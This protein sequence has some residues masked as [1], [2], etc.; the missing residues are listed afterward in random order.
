MSRSCEELLDPARYGQNLANADVIL[1]NA[2][3]LWP[4]NASEETG[5]E[6][7]MSVAL[8]DLKPSEVSR[9]RMAMQEAAFME[10]KVMIQSLETSH[11]ADELVGLAAASELS[12]LDWVVAVPKDAVPD[13]VQLKHVPGVGQS[14]LAGICIAV[15]DRPD[16]VDAEKFDLVVTEASNVS[17]VAGQVFRML[18]TLT[19]SYTLTCLDSVDIAYTL[20]L[21]Q[22]IQLVTTY[23]N[24][25]AQALIFP[26]PSVK[27]RLA[28]ARGIFWAGDISIDDPDPTCYM[29]IYKAIRQSCPDVAE[30]IF[31]VS[32]GQRADAL[33]G[34]LRAVDLL[35]S[36]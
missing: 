7:P 23:W 21:G 20:N 22:D 5:E 33:R 4:T 9:A 35:C 14:G 3:L 36:I 1:V 16:L 17:L 18:S 8:V 32:V 26:S 12:Y 11:W 34:P 29:K 10:G 2:R 30:V 28:Q 19:A 31:G 13:L 24:D 15:T 25:S 6:T 27:N